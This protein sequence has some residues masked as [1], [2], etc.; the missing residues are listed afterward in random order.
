MELDAENRKLAMLEAHDFALVGSSRD[1]QR[2]VI[3]QFDDER[4]V[5]A[6]IAPKIS[7]S[8]PIPLRGTPSSRCRSSNS[9]RSLRCFS[10]YPRSGWALVSRCLWRKHIAQEAP[11]RCV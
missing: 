9:T 5:A 11:R 2:R 6:G 8:R 7:G 1:H 3:V 4:M 10:T